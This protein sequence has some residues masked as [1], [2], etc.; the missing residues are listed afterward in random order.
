M[1][2]FSDLLATEFF[3]TIT[4][5][6]QTTQVGLLTPLIF[7]QGDTVLVDGNEILPRFQHLCQHGRLTITQPFYQWLHD[8]TGQGWLLRPHP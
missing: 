8:V 2:N 3:L 1:K 4:V 5:N 6:G 7:A